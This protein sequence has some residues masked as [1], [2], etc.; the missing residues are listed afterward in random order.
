MAT[1]HGGQINHEGKHDN[2]IFRPY[3]KSWIYKPSRA[4]NPPCSLH[5]HPFI[6][7][8]SSTGCDR[9]NDHRTRVIVLRSTL[10]YNSFVSGDL[11]LL[12]APINFHFLCVAFGSGDCWMDCNQAIHRMK[13]LGGTIGHRRLPL[14]RM[15]SCRSRN[16]QLQL[17]AILSR[18]RNG[19]VGL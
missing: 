10:N 13:S 6:L 19:T 16:L 4:S 11:F 18:Y 8:R 15:L 12:I 2:S 7:P 17:C 1:T 3:T 5:T 9:A 14:E